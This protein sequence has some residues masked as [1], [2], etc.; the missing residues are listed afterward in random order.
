MSAAAMPISCGAARSEARA[1]G[2]GRGEDWRAAAA[3]LQVL[4]RHRAEVLLLLGGRGL[5]RLGGLLL[6]RG[7]H[8][9]GC[10]DLRWREAPKVA[11]N[12]DAARG[13][14][15][16]LGVGA[17]RDFLCQ[18]ARSRNWPRERPCCAKICS[19]RE[20][21]GANHPILSWDSA[22]SRLPT[23]QPAAAAAP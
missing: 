11:L 4:Q 19:W 17:R 9:L 20:A 18:R 2:R 10:R 1:A 8:R 14:C 3:H 22:S 15:G 6:H 7:G 21:L 16:S 12:T 13:A 5:H 23:S